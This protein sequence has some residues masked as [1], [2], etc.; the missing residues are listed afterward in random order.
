MYPVHSYEIPAIHVRRTAG[1]G[2]HP[3]P[4]TAGTRPVFPPLRLRRRGDGCHQR[5]AQ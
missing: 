3:S 1:P 4:G 5:R 2:G